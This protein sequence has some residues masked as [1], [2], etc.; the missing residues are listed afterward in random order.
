MKVGFIGI[1]NIGRPMANQIL[2]NGFNLTIYDIDHTNAKTLLDKGA[3]WA[4][5][6]REVSESSD[7]IC[8]CLPGP[9]EME[10]VIFGENGILQGIQRNSI[11]IDLTTNSPALVRKVHD[12]LAARNVSMLDAPVSGGMEG[13]LTRDLTVLVGGNSNTLKKCA[14]VLEAISKTVL[15]VGPIGAGCICKITHNCASFVRS[16]ALIECL[17]VGVKAGVDADILIDAFTTG[18]LG[19]NMDF[20]VRMPATIFKGDFEPRFA[21]KIAHKDITLATELADEIDVPMKLAE[22][23]KAEMA[24]AL[25]RGMGDRDS[26][27]FLTLQEDRANVKVRKNVDGSARQVDT[28]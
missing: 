15:H 17:T 12:V 14:P 19:T 28:P 3:V 1:G 7:I 16:M 10:S 11:Y 13:A 21:L 6:P 23:C 9:R 8:T 24:E 5:S 26:S 2:E 27:I 22:A 20:L 25:D 18:A 4:K